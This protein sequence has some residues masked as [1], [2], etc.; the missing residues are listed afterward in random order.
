MILFF[1]NKAYTDESMKVMVLPFDIHAL[2]ALAYLETEIPKV[3]GEYLK[4]EGAEL[5]TPDVESDASLKAALKNR[6]RIRELGVKGGADYVIWGSLTWIGQKFSLDAKLISP[7]TDDPPDVFVQEGEGVENLLGSVKILSRDFSVKLFKRETVAGVSIVGNQ[8]IESDA[9]K[10]IIKT[11][12]GEIY[13]AKRIPEDIKAIYSMGYFDDI[14]VDVKDVPDGKS[15]V[16]TV[17]E[18]QTIRQI[19]INGNKVFEDDEVME[20]IDIRT[21]SI[22][23]IFR[24]QTNIDQIDEL[25]KEKNYHNVDVKYSIRPLKNNQADLIFVIKEGEKLLIKKI[26]FEGNS[27]YTDKE[28]LDLMKTSQK[29]FFSWITSS[30]DLK[31]EDLEE[32]IQRLRGYYHKTGY[33]TARISDPHVEYKTKWI[34][35]TIKIEE[36]ERLK[37]GKVDVSGDLIV[38]KSLFLG[39]LEVGKETYFDREL[40]QNDMLAIT[41][42]YGN[43]GYAYADVVPRI[44]D[45]DE[46]GLTDINYIIDKGQQ[47]YFEKIII[48]GNDRTRD[49]VIRR[50]LK[51]YEEGLYNGVLLKRSVRN[52]HRLDFFEDVKV[53]TS[54]GSADD[55]MIVRLKVEEKSTGSFNFGGG[56]SSVDRAFAMVSLEERN[57]FGRGQDLS[58]RAEVGGRSVRYSLSFTEPWLFD[59]PL[60]A[61][62][63][64]YNWRKDYDTYDKDSMGIALR[65]SY[66][67]FDFTRL[68]LSYTFDIG[69]IR[70]VNFFAAESVKKLE[71]T[72]ITSAIS[73]AIRYDSRDRKFNPTEGMNHSFTVQYAGLG[74]DIGFA[75]FTAESGL[76]IPVFKKL[77]FFA[78][79]VGGY[80]RKVPGKTIPDYER[81]YLGGMNSL[82]GYDWRDISPEE[83]NS[84]GLVSKIGGDKKVQFNF[85]LLLPIIEK[86]GVIMVAFFDMGDVY[87]NHQRVDFGTLR[88]SAGYGF[89]WYSPMGP[90]R[91]EYGYILNPKPGE[92]SGGRWEFTMG[93]AF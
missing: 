5:L 88:R 92:P 87:D 20:T 85:E 3:I 16:F 34:Y 30:G 38:N 83:V 76:Y 19:I 35:V 42:L 57:L 6:D 91:L 89:R 7:R 23:N 24:V 69:D 12:A 21:G 39:M 82:R 13:L 54:R 46:N 40:M 53:D 9:I 41:D 29:G 33:I 22:L 86:S 61:G 37:V 18:K 32:D 36:G 56:Y 15:I 71:G 14:R 81:F 68:Y 17:K 4:Q 1:V 78:H 45:P 59:I 79:A 25:Y 2:E 63:D 70:N 77:V 67:I 50:E 90:I 74:G 80:V 93:N 64:L 11:A 44:G 10:R 43:L 55:R 62:F 66:R 84:F 26:R 49:K 31:M 47:V 52:L 75:K 65:S 51:I 73:T 27:S 8:R 28:L 60:A 72:N 48:A 58:L